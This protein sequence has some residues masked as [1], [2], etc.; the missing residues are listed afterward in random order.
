MLRQ[1]EALR[2]GDFDLFKTLVIESGA[3]SYQYLQ[4]VFSTS[5]P[6]EQGV[7]VTLALCERLLKSRGG[8]WRVHGGGFAGTVQTF[9]PMDYV[10]TFREKNWTLSWERVPATCFLSVL[11]EVP[12]SYKGRKKQSFSLIEETKAK[13]AAAFQKQGRSIFEPQLPFLRFLPYFYQ[14]DARQFLSKAKAVL[15]PIL[16]LECCFFYFEALKS[17]KV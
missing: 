14:K 16:L 17:R 12:R 2:A 3:S 4:N 11:L 9:V 7:S 5:Y 10:E 15:R 1:V 6:G 13:N 8:A